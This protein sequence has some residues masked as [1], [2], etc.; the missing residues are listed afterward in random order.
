MEP[1]ATSSRSFN[2]SKGQINPRVWSSARPS[3]NTSINDSPTLNHHLSSSAHSSPWSQSLNLGQ[4]HNYLLAELANHSLG[5]DLPPSIQGSYPNTWEHQYPSSIPPEALAALFANGSIQSVPSS[6]PGTPSLSSS[7]HSSYQTMSSISHS[8]SGSPLSTHFKFTPGPPSKNPLPRSNSD[9]KAKLAGGDR[10]TAFG[11]LHR[12]NSTSNVIQ[13]T[14]HSSGQQ[15]RDNSVGTHIHPQQRPGERSNPHVPP[16]LWMSPASTSVS[17]PSPYRLNDLSPIPLPGPKL[18]I[19]KSPYGQSPVVS[20]KSPSLESKSTLFTDLFAEELFTPTRGSLSPQA[21]SPY[22]SPRIIGSPVMQS[23]E[24]EPDPEQLAKDDPLATQVWRMYA[25]TKA[26]LPHA[27]RMENLSWRMMALALKKKKGEDDEAA[28]K[29]PEDEKTASSKDATV[30]D[31]V[32]PEQSQTSEVDPSRPSDERGR[33]I[34]KGKAR[35]RVVG[36]DGTNQDGFEEPESRPPEPGPTFEQHGLFNIAPFDAR[37]SFPP[38]HDGFKSLDNLHQPKGSSKVGLSTSPSIPIPGSSA[39]PSMLSLTYGRRSSPPSMHELPSVFEDQAEASNPE[40]R[41]L[42]D[43]SFSE[44]NSPAFAPSS[45]PSTGLHGLSRVPSAP[46]AHFPQI[47]QRSFP[48]HVRKTSFDHTVSKDGIMTGVSGR[49]QVNGRPL[50]PPAENHVG[51]KRRAEAP[52]SESMLRADPSLVGASGM[53]PSLLQPEQVEESGG[54]FPTSM[55]NFSFPPYEGLF[56]LP[57]ATPSSEDRHHDFN[58]YRQPHQSRQEPSESSINSHR[59]SVSDATLQTPINEGLSAASAAA[60]SV[61]AEGYASLDA[62]NLANANGSLFDYG[63]LLGLVYPS[64]LDGANAYTHVDPNQLLTGHGDDGTGAAGGGGGAGVL[65]GFTH[66]HTSPSSDGWGNNFSADASPEPHNI[67]TEST[68]PSVEAAPQTS[69]QTTKAMNGRKYIALKPDVPKKTSVP[70]TATSSPGDLRSSS[71]TPDN[72]GLEKGASDEG[73][74]PPTLCTNCHTTNTPLWRRDPEGQPLCNACGLFFKLH[75]VVRPLS[76]KTDV[77]KKRNRASGTSNNAR[78]STLPK[79]AS[80]TSRPRSQSGSVLSGNVVGMRSPQPTASYQ[81][82]LR[83]VASKDVNGNRHLNHRVSRTD[84]DFEQALRAEGTVMLKEGLDMNT[85]GVDSAPSPANSSLTSTASSR[86]YTPRKQQS[87]TPTVVPPTPS[88]ASAPSPRTEGSSSHSSSSQDV[89]YDAEEMSSTNIDRQTNRRSMYRSPGT[90]SSPDLATLLRKAKEKGTVVGAQH[91]REP[92]RES[93][94]PP[95]PTERPSS[96]GRQRSSTTVASTPSTPQSTPMPKSKFKSP[97]HDTGS[98]WTLPSPRQ[99]ENGTIRKTDASLPPTPTTPHHEPPSLYD[100]FAPPVPPIPI[101]HQPKPLSGSP[102]ADAFISSNTLRPAGMSKPLPEIT[103]SMKDNDDFDD[104]SIVFVEQTPSDKDTTRKPDLIT[105]EKA[106]RRRSRSISETELKRAMFAGT[107]SQPMAQSERRP[108][109]PRID[110]ITFTGILDDLKGGLSQLDSAY[111]SLDLQ[112]SS[113]APKTII[114]S[115]I[116]GTS[117]QSNTPTEAKRSSVIPTPPGTPKLVLQIPPDQLESDTPM[118]I[119]PII[120]PRSSS[121]QMPRPTARPTSLIGSPYG[122]SRHASSP[123]RSR[124]ANIHNG[125]DTRLGTLHRSV[126]SSSEPSLIP[127]GE[128]PARRGS[129]YDLQANDLTLS[130]FPSAAQSTTSQSVTPTEDSIEMETRAKELASRCWA[131]DE[132]FLAK[133]KIAEWLGGLRLCSKLYLK[134]ETQQVDRILEEFSRRYWD[135]NPNGIYGSANLHVADLTTR[136]SRTQFVRNTLAA[137]QA[138]VQPTPSAD[139]STS[140]LMYDDSRSVRGP[141]QD[142]SESRVRSKRSDSI[143]S[144]NSVSKEGSG[145]TMLRSRSL[146]AQQDRLTTLKRGSVRGLQSI[147]GAQGTS[148]YSSNSSID[149]RVSPSPSFATSTHEAMYNSS[150]S[151]LTPTLGFA[152]NLSHTIIREAQEDD[153]RSLRSDASDDTTISISDEELALLGAPWAKEGML[154]RKQYWESTGKRAR[155]K[156]WMDVFVVIQKGELNMFTFGDHSSGASGTFGGGNWLNNAHSVGN[157]HLAHSLAHS[158]PP[159]G[160]NRQRPYCMVLTMANGAVFFFQAGTE[161]LVNEWVSTCNYWAARTSKQPLAGGVSNMEYGWNRVL[162][163]LPHGRSQLE[164]ESVKDFTD[165]MSIKSGRSTRSKFGGWKEGAATVRGMQSPWAERTT[166]N[167]WKAPLPP[168]VSSVHDEETQL[169]ALRKHVLSL[170]RD[171]EKHNDFREPMTALYQ[172]RTANAIKAQS[173]WEKKSQWLLTEIVKY[174]S[175]IDSLQAAMSLRLKKRGEKA[176]ERALN[177]TA[178]ETMAS[179]GKWKAPEE[180][181][182]REEAEP[183]TP[184]PS[185]RFDTHLYRQETAEDEKTLEN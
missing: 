29:K 110:D 124:T 166:I 34:D 47:E 101:E 115:S 7:Y 132:D 40:V 149:G 128:V 99:K 111:D 135:C 59:Y 112:A 185:Q 103:D 11:S 170:K 146:R 154:C 134:A 70:G 139:V 27:Q 46:Y 77:I 24:I 109:V 100:I 184:G 85:L 125:R 156:A 55:F 10:S 62:A 136:M 84:L 57:S 95:L 35:V 161:E 94:P 104:K 151:F 129:Q 82:G 137:I 96:S 14:K 178:A 26:T 91:K 30:V 56:S 123:L 39:G 25:K 177:G 80:S 183:L 9:L 158:L 17:S 150:S 45:L 176:L 147:M 106:R 60:R 13:T 98:E 179:K 15:Y 28:V 138:S 16:S 54:I 31:S 37:Y 114:R 51:Q 116:D 168:I 173:N 21:T 61:M 71:S 64:A 182:I 162:D 172:P 52:H 3:L 130:R 73:D 155:D 43:R 140:D 76:L 122:A 131:E 78:K 19:D 5:I 41:F 148:P 164:T 133:E 159:P 42:H 67:S 36:F 152:S 142:G 145:G 105:I 121:L 92:R 68:P 48:R 174:D 181:T 93:P 119:S 65:G 118:K 63:H 83:P 58:P 126:A 127:N 23:N 69:G 12:T 87:A 38:M 169:D 44:V 86:H 175:Y 141:A 153:D 143:T 33:R 8:Q 2:D 74:Q 20:S 79:L 50:A 171:L 81:N 90:S 66:F 32:K 117:S 160:Y 88:P 157:V 120:P 180:D 89:F 49:H 22:T 6:P 167:D 144:W 1:P 75:G 102:I 165:T 113:I 18:Q 163:A 97:K 107:P 72:T 108:S 4:N 53:P